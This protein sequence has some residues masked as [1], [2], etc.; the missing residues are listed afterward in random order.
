[1][2][3]AD[4]DTRIFPAQAEESR[5]QSTTHKTAYC[6]IWVRDDLAAEAYSE[7]SAFPAGVVGAGLR[8]D[9]GTVAGGARHF[10][11]RGRDN[12]VVRA[13]IIGGGWRIREPEA[14]YI[15]S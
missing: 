13:S 1:V 9:L 14:V 6:K 10:L 7:L 2:G 4:L 5:L 15:S 3:N 11:G 12:I 8:K